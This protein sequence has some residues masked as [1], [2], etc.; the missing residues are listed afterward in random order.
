M[1]RNIVSLGIIIACYP[2]ARIIL[3]MIFKKS[4]MFKVSNAIV[5]LLL[6]VSF[7]MSLVGQF[8]QIHTLWAI[9]L[10]FTIG[11]IIFLQIRNQLTKPLSQSIEQVKELSQGNLKIQVEKSKLTNE[12]GILNNSI[13]ELTD[14]LKRI[15]S[16]IQSSS[17]N[18]T[19]SSIHLSSLSEELSQGASEQA[20]N[21]EEVSSTFEEIS[22]TISDSLLKA[23]STG[24]ISI[25]VKDA[26]LNLVGG[27][28]NAIKSS[29]LI[30]QKIEGVNDISF[31]TNILALNAAVE[32]ARAG[33][34][35]LGFA[36]VADEVRRLADSSKILSNE[37][38][39]IS[40]TTRKE[41]SQSE[42]E[43]G[44]LLPL[45]ETSTNS[46]QE[47]VQANME[48]ANGVVQ[49]NDAIQQ[50]NGV[51]QQNASA[52]EE[53]AAQAE[54]LAAQAEGLTDL[55]SYFKL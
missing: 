16:E 46:V 21:L 54:E 11:S 15:I 17:K 39:I 13:Y 9:P 8:G 48:Q 42:Q 1:E 7:D 26:V 19:S 34:H 4:I 43:I 3:R 10:N 2:V 52:S 14:S 28:K 50:M 37:V 5:I 27:I 45:L 25:Q 38:V 49:V 6:L 24:K 36:V 31:Q 32:A 30:S 51:T 44:A 12:L 29:D 40:A 20:T 33:E 35:G 41:A 55:I 47:I 23:E 53:M 22:A 18:L